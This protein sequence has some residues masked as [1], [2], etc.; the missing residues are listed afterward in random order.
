[1]TRNGTPDAPPRLEC[2]GLRVGDCSVPPFRVGAGRSVCLHV[3]LPSPAWWDRLV[4]LLTGKRAHPALRFFGSVASLD[5]PM[6]RRH[7]WG[8][9]HDPSV[10]DWL[11]AEKGLTPA[12]A[13]SVLGRVGLPGDIR[14]GRVGWNERTLLAL[15]ACL[16]RPADLLVFDTGGNDPRGVS[17]IL[18]R[19]AARP[20]GLSLLYVK[21]RL[22]AD[23]PC[24]SGA[25]CVSLGCRPLQPS[26]AE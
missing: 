1:M 7:W 13:S 15:E 20:P 10:R 11:V 25:E 6:P 24:L 19:L 3:P 9:L 17:S 21:A 12:E 22:S 2:D 23:E 14:I 8:R 26:A 16:L 4:P 5:R 18:Q